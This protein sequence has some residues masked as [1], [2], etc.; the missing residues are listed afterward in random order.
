MDVCMDGQNLSAMRQIRRGI[1]FI[2]EVPPEIWEQVATVSG[3]QGI[4]R[5]CAVSHTF[6]SIISPLLY[7]MTTHPSLTRTQSALL[8]RTI[9]RVRASIHPIHAIKIVSFSGNSRQCRDALWNLADI[10]S[11]G[12]PI[13]GALLQSL[14]WNLPETAGLRILLAPG[15]FPNLKQIS[16]C[17]TVDKSKTGFDFV[18][19]PGLEKLEFSL[20]FIVGKDPN[21]AGGHS[22]HSG[23]HSPFSLHLRRS[24]KP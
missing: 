21:P 23:K 19:I 6:Y 13:R 2:L 17:A 24:C 8:T 9:R 12:Q 1:L 3:R 5:L 10:S 4:A 18:R 22:R 14:E 20:K 11:P 15:Y 16:V 7:G